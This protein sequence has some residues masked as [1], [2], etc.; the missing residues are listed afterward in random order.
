[1]V[2]IIQN[3]G[4]ELEIASEEVDGGRGAKLGVIDKRNGPH[5]LPGKFVT[6]DVN[7]R[8]PLFG[9]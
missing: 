8:L 4:N 3:L 1:L 5:E 2:L 6:K 9:G 7:N